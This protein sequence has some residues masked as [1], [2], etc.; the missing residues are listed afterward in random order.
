VVVGL[1][2]LLLAAAGGGFAYLVSQ[3]DGSGTFAREIDEP[4]ST[5]VHTVRAP[6]DT[7]VLIRVSPSDESF[8]PV[9]GVSANPA[10]ADRLTEFF[11]TDGPLPDDVFSG[12]V[13]EDTRLLAVSDAT[14]PGEEEFT[15]V[16]TPFGGD[17]EVLVTGAGTTVGGFELEVVLRPF[18]GPPDGQAYLQELSGQSFLD[19]YEQP[20]SPIEDILDDFTEDGD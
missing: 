15:Y 4:G 3:V 6:E 14:G 17:V 19:D 20:R 10:T 1:V 5:L 13:P 8:D 11:G 7:V 2:V 9:I 12:V 16:A 18:D